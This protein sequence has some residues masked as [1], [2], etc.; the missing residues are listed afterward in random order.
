MRTLALLH[1]WL[2]I[3]SCLLFAM[4]FASGMVMHVVPFPSLTE[5]ERIAGLDP[6]DASRI[7]REPADA[8][9]EGGAA[10]ATRIRLMQRPDGPVYIASGP[11]GLWAAHAEAPGPAAVQSPELA[12]TIARRHA[13]NRGLDASRASLAARDM[14]DQWT[15]PNGFD[16]HRPLYR[17]ALNDAFATEVYVSSTTGEVVLDTTRRERFWNWV[18]SI[19]HWIYP[20]LLRRDWARW[21][22]TVWTLSLLA[23]FAALAGAVLGIARI[24]WRAGMPRTPYKGWHAW[25]HAAGLVTMTFLTTWIFSGWLS[26]DHGRLFSTGHPGASEVAALAAA[27]DWRDVH[28]PRLSAAREI[29]WFALAGRLYRRDRLSLDA[30]L[31]SVSAQAGSEPDGPHGVLRAAD[32][33]DSALARGGLACNTAARVAADDAYPVASRMPGAPVYRAV[34]GGV[35]LHIDGASGALI[36]RLDPSRRAYRWLYS[37]LHTLDL[38]ALTGRPM[39]RSLLIES[40]CFLGL[41]FSLTGIVLAWRR[42]R[43]AGR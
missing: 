17:V 13:G 8:V 43:R 22:A 23:L 41:A 33:I 24:G 28:A 10:R 32:D 16:P 4:W 35:W 12:L 9:R 31:V 27:P 29:E 37:A 2:G 25:H 36:E 42:L 30:Q 19:P 1:R 5:A 20:T 18:G 11:F 39:L 7:T 40:L 34:C 14:H 21:D 15:V 3:A 38:P 6:I 26:M